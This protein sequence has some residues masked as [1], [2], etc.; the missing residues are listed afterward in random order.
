MRG[1]FFH[2]RLFHGRTLRLVVRCWKG[3]FS[4]LAP[5]LA[6]TLP[7]LAFSSPLLNGSPSSPRSSN[8]LQ[9]LLRKRH[10]AVL[11]DAGCFTMLAISL[12]LLLPPCSCSLVS[13]SLSL[14]IPSACQMGLSR[15]S[16]KQADKG[17]GSF[18]ES[19]GASDHLPKAPIARVEAITLLFCAQE[20][21]P[22]Q[23]G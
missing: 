6:A 9:R 22:D 14:R 15:A 21:D 5:S 3:S 4:V 2:T 7:C 23:I 19:L 11:Y 20:S 17:F 1:A 8:H 16:S 10:H 13:P 18:A 12:L